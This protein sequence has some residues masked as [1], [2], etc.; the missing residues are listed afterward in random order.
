M[1]SRSRAIV[2]DLKSMKNLGWFGRPGAWIFLLKKYLPSQFAP[3]LDD[4]F[5]GPLDRKVLRGYRWS[6]LSRQRAELLVPDRFPNED[7]SH[8]EVSPSTIVDAATFLVEGFT[9]YTC[10]LDQAIQLKLVELRLERLESAKIQ[11]VLRLVVT[12][13]HEERERW[14]LHLR[15]EGK[16][17]HEF[18]VSVMDSNDRVFESL[19]LNCEFETQDEL[20]ISSPKN[21]KKVDVR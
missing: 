19:F 4:L 11:G 17:H 3:F 10:N 14:L 12:W 9:R 5:W 15:T 6:R 21:K 8:S 1:I 2:K 18:N 16:A 20:Q 7:R 13:S